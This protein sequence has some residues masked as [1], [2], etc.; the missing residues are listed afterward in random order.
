MNNLSRAFGNRLVTIRKTKRL[1]Q[2]K[3]AEKTGI[4]I[5]FLSMLERG[6]RSPSFTTIEHLANALAI[7]VKELFDFSKDTL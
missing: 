3:L 4:S 7:E 6:Y 2:E 1:T 5:D